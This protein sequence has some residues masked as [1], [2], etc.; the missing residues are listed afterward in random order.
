VWGEGGS[1]VPVA[2]AAAITSVA[3]IT[4]IKVRERRQSRHRLRHSLERAA[5][6]TSER[7]ATV[8][9]V[10]ARPI[11]A[12]PDIAA[13]LAVG[14]LMQMFTVMARQGE[15]MRGRRRLR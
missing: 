8:G 6:A 2:I 9:R 1:A 14:A 13:D 5:T 12:R 7:L 10:A 15:T 3:V 11:A 4:A